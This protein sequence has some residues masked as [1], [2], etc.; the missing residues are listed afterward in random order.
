MSGS[1]TSHEA[2]W[3]RLYHF[4]VFILFRVDLEQRRSREEKEME[5]ILELRTEGVWLFIVG[6]DLE[7]LHKGTWKKYVPTAVQL[8]WRGRCADGRCESHLEKAEQRSNLIW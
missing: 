8:L 2:E 1:T 3:H 6:L 5:R 4:I 7:S